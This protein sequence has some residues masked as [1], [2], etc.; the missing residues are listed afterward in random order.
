MAQKKK[1]K[2]LYIRVDEVILEHHAKSELIKEQFTPTFE[3]KSLSTRNASASPP[4]KYFGHS[5]RVLKSDLIKPEKSVILKRMGSKSVR[6]SSY[7]GN[8]K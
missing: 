1:K 7:S 2:P 8:R 4:R 5:P 3:A 6:N